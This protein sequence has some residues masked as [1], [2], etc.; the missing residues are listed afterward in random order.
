[1]KEKLNREL[2]GLRTD[3]KKVVEKIS[4]YI[5]VENMGTYHVIPL[6]EP[7][8]KKED[9]SKKDLVVGAVALGVGYM[10]GKSVKNKE[11]PEEKKT[12]NIGEIIDEVKR[13]LEEEGE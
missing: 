6:E 9:L 3:R 13:E 4:S 11:E 12:S 8:T 10:L 7:P 1:M 2:G 5:Q